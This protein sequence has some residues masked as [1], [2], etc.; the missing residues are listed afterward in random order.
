MLLDYV[1]NNMP[2]ENTTIVSPDA[3][4]IKVS[5]QSAAK[6]GNLPL[7]FIHKPVTPP[8]RT[9]PKRMALSARSKVTTAWWSTT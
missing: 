4:R 5:E 2:L 8:P 9:M 7:A 3:G 1:R 6:L